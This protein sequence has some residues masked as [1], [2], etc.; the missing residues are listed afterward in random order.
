MYKEELRDL[1]HS[2]NI[3]RV[4]KSRITRCIGHVARM[5]GEEECLQGLGGE[6]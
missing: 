4:I 6:T 3:I 2:P 1:Y 5:G